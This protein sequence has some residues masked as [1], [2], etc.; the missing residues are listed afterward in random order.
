MEQHQQELQH[1]NRIKEYINNKLLP[2]LKVFLYPEKQG[3]SDM[4]SEADYSIKQKIAVFERSK[5]LVSMAHAAD[6]IF[7]GFHAL[8][9]DALV[10]SISSSSAYSRALAGTVN[11]NELEV[12][13]ST[14]QHT[15]TAA[16]SKLTESEFMQ[17]YLSE[18]KK[19][20][21]RMWF[22]TEQEKAMMSGAATALDVVK[23]D[24]RRVMKDL[25]LQT[26]RASTPKGGV[27]ISWHMFLVSLAVPV[28]MGFAGYAMGQLQLLSGHI[29]L[30]VCAFL[31]T[32]Y[33]AVGI[34][35]FINNYNH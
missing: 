33:L 10:P 32:L 5:K 11:V 21:R 3:E 22:L 29:S 19:S 1:C 8:L 6:D 34:S 14:L 30:I 12:L 23:Q 20:E 9:D 28:A 26:E 4:P 16:A 13:N 15:L 25:A 27:W 17:K 7:V 35:K 24:A 31:L 2:S 18:A